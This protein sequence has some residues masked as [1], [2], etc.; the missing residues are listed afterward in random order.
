MNDLK[1]ESSKSKKNNIDYD[2]IIKNLLDKF[3]IDSLK[4]IDKDE[5]FN[6]ITK[7]D[8]FGGTLYRGNVKEDIILSDIEVSMIVD[9]DIEKYGAYVTFFP[10]VDGTRS[11]EI[12]VKK[13]IVGR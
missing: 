3:S 9:S 5:I 10:R 8:T 1:L 7:N 13:S 12:K 2:T 11:F 4:E 6:S